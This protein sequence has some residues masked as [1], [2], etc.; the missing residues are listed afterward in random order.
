[1]QKGLR[2]TG[3]LLVIGNNTLAGIVAEICDWRFPMSAA[4]HSYESELRELADNL[5]STTSKRGDLKLV[6]VAPSQSPKP[7]CR[8]QEY[9]V[10]LKVCT[11]LLTEWMKEFK[12]LIVLVSLIGFFVWEV[13]GVMIRLHVT[14]F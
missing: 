5:V 9:L 1:M 10:E 3:I 14:P 7:L 11:T 13:I 6:Q 2:P 8:V 4:P 12:E